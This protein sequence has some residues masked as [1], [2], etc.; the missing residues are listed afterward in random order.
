MPK[1]VKGIYEKGKISLPLNEIPEENT[2]IQVIVVFL[3]PDAKIHRKEGL[4]EDLDINLQSAPE[5][6]SSA[7]ESI[8]ST[9]KSKFF[10]LPSEHFGATS[11][12]EIDKI[13]AE[14]ALGRK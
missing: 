12:S 10:S 1:A 11:A 7:E 3:E 4:L 13:I 6:E 2:K 14:E 5:K 8:F 9:K